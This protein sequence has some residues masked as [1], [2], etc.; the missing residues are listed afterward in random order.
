MSLSGLLADFGWSGKRNRT[1]MVTALDALVTSTFAVD[2]WDA[3]TGELRFLSR[4]HLLDRW[5]AG[6]AHRSGR[7]G[8]EGFVDLGGWLHEQLRSAHTTFIDWNQLRALERPLAKRLLIFLEAE[9]FEGNAK[10]WRIGNE[11][12]ATL[13]MAA[14]KPRDARMRIA[15]AGDELVA[16]VARYA[17]V[18]VEPRSTGRGWVLTARRR[19]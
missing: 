19:A 1:R 5:E 15:T 7:H 3:R 14:S 10:R 18:N 11:L 2:V 16:A 8:L 9:R 6:V 4:F 12:F 13:G 17:A